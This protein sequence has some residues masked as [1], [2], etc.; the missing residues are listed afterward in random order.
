MPFRMDLT[1]TDATG[2]P[3]VGGG[4]LQLVLRKDAA[5]VFD[6]GFTAYAKPQITMTAPTGNDWTHVIVRI[7]PESYTL[8]G[9]TLNR[10]GENVYCNNAAAQIALS[11]DGNL[12]LALPLLRVREAPG[13]IPGRD[14]AAGDDL[15]S[16]WLERRQG[17]S[18]AI[19]RELLSTG[20][21]AS[22]TAVAAVAEPD[23]FGKFSPFIDPDA[24]DGWDRFKINARREDPAA[25]GAPLLLEYGE[26]G[27][28][29]AGGPR[30]LVGVWVPTRPSPAPAGPYPAWRDMAAFLHPSTAKSWF[31][32]SSWPYTANYPFVVSNNTNIA[33]G[34]PV[35]PFQPYVNLALKHLTGIWSQFQRIGRD[36]V[37][38]V[39]IL[40]HPKAKSQDEADYGLPFTTQ[41]GLARLLAEV[42][43]HLHQ[44]RY[45]WPGMGLNTFG[46]ATAPTTPPR[47]PADATAFFTESVKPPVVRR[48][49]AA[50]FSASSA[51]MN[52]L[53]TQRS[54]SN[55][56]FPAER[57]SAR[58]S[59]PFRAWTEA[60]VIDPIFGTAT[61]AATTFE[62]SLQAWFDA[63]ETRRFHII[64]SGTTGGGNPDALYPKFGKRTASRQRVTGTDT[65]RVGNYWIGQ[66]DR[67]AAMFCTNPL[68]TATTAN[69]ALWPTF[70]TTPDP[71]TIHGFTFALASGMILGWTLLGQT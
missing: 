30:F 14:P 19:Y 24:A 42:N 65:T 1:L 58:T 57:W 51:Q 22:R 35:L 29:T 46:G 17:M 69:A 43:L 21:L 45:G 32:E 4:R 18:A 27:S 23:R 10:S 60:W 13:A 44:I 12:T 48:V 37:F 15:K 64:H 33:A 26:T 68:L 31:P 5:A 41:S 38:V 67:W 59:D 52:T 50:A 53:M 7:E 54:T 55:S 70:E 63:N 39:P 56:R 20:M 40:P 2:Q 28:V 62:A 3:P 16:V 66:G 6:S 61:V 36:E 11:D 71:D 25:S 34:Q 9:V 49:A 47:S 8:Q